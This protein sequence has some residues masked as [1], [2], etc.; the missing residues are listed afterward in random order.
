MET[1]SR[2]ASIIDPVDVGSEQSVQTQKFKY[3]LRAGPDP[4]QPYV[5]PHTH[6]IKKQQRC[7]VVINRIFVLDYFQ[8]L[9]KHKYFLLVESENLA[10]QIL[11]PQTE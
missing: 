5:S 7:A 9:L 1:K 2:G 10:P 4:T 8:F 11:A 3:S 6:S